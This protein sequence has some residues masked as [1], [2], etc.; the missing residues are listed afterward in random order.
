M[1]AMTSCSAPTG[2]TVAMKGCCLG[3]PFLLRGVLGG[4][5]AGGGGCGAGRRPSPWQP[6]EPQTAGLPGDPRPLQTSGRSA[7][8]GQEL[9][10]APP[11][12]TRERV[13]VERPPEAA[14]WTSRCGSTRGPAASTRPPSSLRMPILPCQ[15][16]RAPSLCFLTRAAHARPSGALSSR[17]SGLAVSIPAA[18]ARPRSCSTPPGSRGLR[19]DGQL[20]LLCFGF[21][22]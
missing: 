15:E 13:P 7:D 2:C 10:S 4:A 1:P 5:R 20:G 19:S 8:C 16:L 21:R 3:D 11:A 12:A 18:H 17:L 22:F 6:C 9:S 14:P